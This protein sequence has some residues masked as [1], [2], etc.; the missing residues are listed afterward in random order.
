MTGSGRG[1]RGGRCGS[2]EVRLRCDAMQGRV[3]RP[4]NGMGTWWIGEGDVFRRQG[5][6]M[7][8]VAGRKGSGDLSMSGAKG[9]APVPTVYARGKFVVVEHG[10]GMPDQ[11]IRCNAAA[12]GRRV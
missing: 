4:M 3:V 8:S 2:G 11:C 7:S 5:V 10:A 12:G 9:A 1:G 6:D